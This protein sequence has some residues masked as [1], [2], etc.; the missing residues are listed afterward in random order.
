M[1]TPSNGRSTYLNG[2]SAA[3]SE[4][5]GVRA[6]VGLLLWEGEPADKA[7]EGLRRGDRGTERGGTPSPCH[8]MKNTR[9]KGNHLGAENGPDQLVT[10]L[11]VK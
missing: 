5:R 4:N 8:A 3:G 10:V 11:P 2:T 6:V 9:S 7:V 1:L